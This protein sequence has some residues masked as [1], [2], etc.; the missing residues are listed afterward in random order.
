MPVNNWTVESSKFT[1]IDIVSPSADDLKAVSEKY[2]LHHYTLKDCLEPDHLPKYE[3]LGDTHFIIT[4]I[5]NETQTT[6]AHTIQEISSKIAVFYNSRF[7][8][9]VHRLPQVILESI[10]L[11]YN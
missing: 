11:I 10:K 1:W 5:L 8:F 3:D 2:N 7:I 4:R 6:K 9:T